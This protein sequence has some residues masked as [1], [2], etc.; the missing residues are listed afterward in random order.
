ML[1]ISDEYRLGC[2]AVLCCQKEVNNLERDQRNTAGMRRGL[3]NKICKELRELELLSLEK[4]I[5]LHTQQC[6]NGATKKMT[7]CMPMMDQMRNI[8]S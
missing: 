6:L 3:E 1:L 5:E 4:T 7:C 8:I 2:C